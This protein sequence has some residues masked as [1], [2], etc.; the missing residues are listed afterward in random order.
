MNVIR[1]IY[2]KQKRN[3]KTRISEHKRIFNGGSGH[4]AIANHLTSEIHC[5][6]DEAN[7]TLIRS[8]HDPLKISIFESL[9]ILKSYKNSQEKF[10][11]KKIELSESRILKIAAQIKPQYRH[12]LNETGING[13]S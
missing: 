1:H 7:I 6:P 8:E 5:F 10:L 4:S 3:L 11:N 2:E 13:K 9:E 12:L